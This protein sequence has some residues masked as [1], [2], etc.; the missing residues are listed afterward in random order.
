MLLFLTTNMAAVTSHANQQF[1][2]TGHFELLSAVKK[3]SL[4]SSTN[5]FVAKSFLQ[6][7]KRKLSIHLN[8]PFPFASF[9]GVFLTLKLAK[10]LVLKTTS[11]S[12]WQLAW[13]LQL[14]VLYSHEAYFFN[15][16]VREIRMW[17]IS[18]FI[19]KV[20]NDYEERLI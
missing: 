8:F 16:S 1:H 7:T 15:Q 3:T 9:N 14:H 11:W 18:D 20:N 10:L 17:V 13:Q 19:M 12:D 5:N 2:W 6:S 4:N